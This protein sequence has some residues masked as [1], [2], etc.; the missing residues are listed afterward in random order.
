MTTKTPHTYSFLWSKRVSLV[1]KYNFYE[2]LSVMLD[3]WVG[4][5]S[6][7]EWVSEKIENPYF[8]LKIWELLTF[9]MSGDPFSKAMK[10]VP[11]IFPAGEVSIIESA[12]QTWKLAETLE[13][14]SEDL[15]ALHN[16]KNKIKWAL[17]YPMIIFIFLFVAVSV[18]LIYVIPNIAPLFE[19]AGI[20][21]PFA[22]QALLATSNFF[23]HNFL[24]LI[25]FI[26]CVVVFFIGYKS[27]ES[28]RASI[29]SL[30]LKLPLVWKVYRNYILADIAGNISSLIWSGVWV[31]KTL[32]LV[33]KSTNNAVYQALFTKIIAKVSSG[34]KIVASME[35]LDLERHYFPNDFLQM[36]A[37]GEKS[38]KLEQVSTK[39][40]KQYNRELDYSLSRLTKWIEPLA[41]LIAGL[42]VVWFA[43]AIFWAILKVTTSVG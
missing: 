37:V 7:L 10:K 43:M 8:R 30:L 13:R 28:G 16:L 15:K 38:A 12:E 41:I 2:Y 27:T 1:D 9:I 4:L 36:L 42:F 11:Q 5:S 35:F 33:G 22:T 24:L 31:I 23:I 29:D 19:D 17:N 6:A 18:V 32:T 25:F 3:S 21:L 40:N 39:I 14:L 34:E 20:E 26:A